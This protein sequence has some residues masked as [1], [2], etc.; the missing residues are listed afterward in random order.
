MPVPLQVVS[1]TLSAVSLQWY[2]LLSRVVLQE[3]Q[4]QPVSTIKRKCTELVS[5]IYVCV[6]ELKI[7][8]FDSGGSRNMGKGHYFS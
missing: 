4:C 5:D 1:L 7:L 6:C 3:V 2:V 8:G